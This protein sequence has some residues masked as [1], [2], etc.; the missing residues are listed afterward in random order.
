MGQRKVFVFSE[1]LSGPFDEGIKSAAVQVIR[2]LSR[3]ASVLTACCEADGSLDNVAVFPGLNRLLLNFKLRRLVRH[4]EPAAILYVP[5]WGGTHASFLRMRVLRLFSPRS[6]A[7]ML[8][9][10]PKE[11]NRL[12]AL[13]LPLLK[14]DQVLTP[15]PRVQREMSKKGIPSEFLPLPT[16]RGKFFPLEGAP[17][18]EEL[19]VKYGLPRDRFIILHVGHING[20]RNLEALIPLQAGDRQV[21]IVSSSS[22]SAVSYKDEGLK[23]LLVAAG[24]III[25][26]YLDSI[27]EVYQLSDLY[28]FPIVRD[29]GCIALPL[30]ILEARACGLPV[31]TTDFGGLRSLFGRSPRGLVFAEPA[32]FPEAV[33]QFRK[34]ETDLFG[35]EQIETVNRSFVQTIQAI[36]ER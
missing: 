10:Q 22:T 27:E 12:Q 7:V 33:A 5:R 11:M 19:R 1:D 36:A 29:I 13:S 31:L 9:L 4:F 28:V 34:G 18:R 14:P 32:T 23:R 20:M 30:S 16:D 15:S 25:D 17:R 35:P 6:K 21:V 24:I 8:I 3:T 2:A 26:D